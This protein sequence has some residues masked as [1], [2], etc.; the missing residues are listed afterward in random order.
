MLTGSMAMAQTPPVLP[1]TDD[2]DFLY[3][4][5]RASARGGL[6]RVQLGVLPLLSTEGVNTRGLIT[7]YADSFVDPRFHDPNME[8]TFLFVSGEG[9][10]GGD[11]TG[12]GDIFEQD[13]PARVHLGFARN[14]GDFYLGVYFGGSLVNAAGGRDDDMSTFPATD[15]DVLTGRMTA[16]DTHL[17][18][19]LGTAGMG[20]RLDF[21]L[22]GNPTING[23]PAFNL[24]MADED[25]LGHGT[26]TRM[27]QATPSLALTWGA[28]MGQL[29]PWAR[30]GFR[31]ANNLTSEATNAA[32]VT[33]TVLRWDSALEVAG[34]ARFLLSDTTAV[35]GELWFNRVAQP[36][37]Q[38]TE[39]GQADTEWVGSIV[40]PAI[41]GHDSSDLSG[42]MGFGLMAYYLQTVEVGST[43]FAFSP[44]V[45]AG[46]VTSL[47]SFSHTTTPA[48]TP[49]EWEEI[50]YSLLTVATGVDLGTRWQAT[51]R[52]ALFTGM[53]V[54]L[55]DWTRWA[56]TGTNT[57]VYGRTD[58]PE[59][60]ESVWAFRGIQVSDFNIGMTFTAAEAIVFG[61]GLN[62]FVNGLFGQANVDGPAV[63]FTVSA[64]F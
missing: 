32:G 26:S 43:T 54:Q 59:A 19:L 8:G 34:G 37:I 11:P 25:N 27:V 4:L 61:L 3:N 29:L 30:V 16:W 50:G 23:L 21:G 58:N 1:D 18:V 52:M 39:P 53:S 41:P 51:Q 31:F 56:E 15:R 17:A 60:G 36:N 64:Q 28:N 33:E 63:N 47:D 55:F 22:T 42:W 35:G 40:I 48:A 14:F 24:S 46:M 7:G 38:R 49:A 10:F 57:S 5:D 62:S 2:L 45:S 44:N 9:L 12:H 13:D 6:R 20:F